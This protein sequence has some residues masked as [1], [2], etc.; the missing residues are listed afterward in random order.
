MPDGNNVDSTV[1]K[2]A[3]QYQA[4]VEKS[5]E[6]NEERANIRENVGKLGIDP[7]AFQVGL[8]M[9]K[10]MS[11]GERSDFTGSLDR[12]LGV[13]DGKEV[14][15][16]GA[17]EM[18]KRD[19]RKKKAEDKKA[20]AG[21]DKAEL[22]KKTD[23]NPKSDPAKGGAGKGSKK[24]DAGTTTPPPGTTPAPDKPVG[25]GEERQETGDELI[26]RVAREENAKREQREGAA[27]VDGRPKSQSQLAAE[28]L[29]QAK[30]GGTTH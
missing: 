28:K 22:D 9:A 4:T 29:E 7:K 3:E 18:R 13:L 12:V 20:K 5:R 27:L 11:K 6:L 24:A 8:R 14:D 10:D 26:A 23:T 25:D 15:L 1:L 19:E 2:L 16:F 30:M 17:E 21:R